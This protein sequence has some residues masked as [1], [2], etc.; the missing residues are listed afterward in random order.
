M[1]S[2]FVSFVSITLAFALVATAAFAA[3]ESEPDD[4][5]SAA[6]QEMALDP[7]TGKM[8]KAP[9]YG[10]QIVF[11][12]TT[13]AAHAD[14]WWGT[15]N[16]RAVRLGLEKLGMVDWAIPRDKWEFVSWYTPE[17]IVKPHL[18]E[19]Y[20]MPDPLTI[21]FHIREGVRWHDKPPMN[22]RE[23][24]AEDIVFNFHRMTGTGSGFTEKSPYAGAVPIMP[25]ESITATDKYAVVFKLKQIDFNALEMIYWESDEAAWIYP[26]EVIKEHGHAHDWRNLVGTGPYMFTDWVRGSSMTYTKNPNYWAFDEKFP[27]N[28]LPHADEIQ[29]LFMSDLATRLAALRTG[30]IALQRDLSID[31]AESLQRTNPELCFQPAAVS[32][33]CQA[34]LPARA[35]L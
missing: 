17:P 26:P 18:A 32:K 23:L 4:S 20:E 1:V 5:A 10:G 33:P 22:G 13:E 2:R 31:D 25:W 15:L 12:D 3:G 21:I 14:A 8:T 29:V 28:R 16:H 30:K 27:K 11:A 34:G 6:E 9:Q 35:S 24:V 7:S 19:S